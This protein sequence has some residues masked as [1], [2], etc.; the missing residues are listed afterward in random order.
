MMIMSFG[1]TINRLTSTSAIIHLSFQNRDE[2]IDFYYSLL[3]K[4][5][6][7]IFITLNDERIDLS[8]E[9]FFLESLFSFNLNEKTNLK[10]LYKNAE[11][12][13]TD[14]EREEFSKIN[15]RIFNFLCK[16][17][18]ENMLGTI[19]SESVELADILNLF[20][21]R[22]ANECNNLTEYFCCILKLILM[23]G[24]IKI[25]FLN[26]LL[27]LF[28][29][30]ELKIIDEELRHLQLLLIDIKF[31]KTDDTT[32]ENMDSFTIDDNLFCY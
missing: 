1:K 9:S 5:S 6:D 11:R 18:P 17:Y 29:E 20:K 22:Y 28:N 27:K 13:L 26:D 30:D 12:S 3:N 4:E 19:F 2:Y 25:V 16:V 23:S 21:Y 31:V 15:E 7:S 10:S 24:K 8:K 14:E 32:V